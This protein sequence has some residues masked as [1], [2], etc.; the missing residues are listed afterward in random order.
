MTDRPSDRLTNGRLTV[1]PSDRRTAALFGRPPVRSSALSA[2][3]LVRWSAIALLASLFP[4]ALPAQLKAADSAWVAGDFGRAQVAYE[5]SLHDNPGSVHALYRLAVLASWAGRLD[6]SLSLLRDAREVEPLDPDVRLYEAKVLSWRG[7]VQEAM[8]RYDSILAVYP[9][10]RDAMFGRA[11]ALAW[12]G[13][14]E[15]ATAEY[16]KLEARDPNDLEVMAGLGEV[17]ALSGDLDE[18]ARQYL[19]A[20]ARNP[21]HLPSLVGL[22]RVRHW[23]GRDRQA[24]DF[25]DRALAI[26]PTEQDELEVARAIRAASRPD[27]EVTVGW[28][29]DSDHNTLW[30]ESL[31]S[32]TP[33]AEALRGFVTVGLNQSSDPVRDA[34]RSGGELGLSWSRGN[35]RAAGALGLR[36]LSPSA[37]PSRTSATARADASLR[38]SS[39]AGVGLTFTHETFDETAFLAAQRIDATD[40][41]GEGDVQLHEGLLLGTGGDLGWLSDG[42][43]RHS[44][45]ISLSQRIAPRLA[46]GV[47]GRYL[48]YDTPGIGYFSPDRYLVGEA[49]GSYT[50]VVRGGWEGRVSGG[51]GVQQV[52]TDGRA[53]SQWH[54]ELRVAHRWAALNEAALSGGISNSALS[55]TTGAYR[56]YTTALTVRLGL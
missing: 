46:A 8:A 50:W 5:R 20:L 53:Q 11:R 14:L 40:L 32:S 21:R 49:R 34:S 56:Y 30:W 48:A 15:E 25:I 18:A 6:S 23:Q 42:N 12:A 2:R 7:A 13:R 33:L 47:F 24:R 38:L 17:A 28:S 36:Y 39:V 52:D 44:L 1:R 29:H 9:E 35:L 4:T 55:S 41:G 10:N 31:T 19:R 37:D 43:S 16:R 22:A 45:V 51:L 26:A 54:F 3:P 27:L